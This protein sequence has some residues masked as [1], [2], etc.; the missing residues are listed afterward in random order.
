MAK[1]KCLHIFFFLYIEIEGLEQGLYARVHDGAVR[2]TYLKIYYIGAE[3][4]NPADICF[5]RVGARA[6]APCRQP[7]IQKYIYVKWRKNNKKTRLTTT[8]YILIFMLFFICTQISTYK[9][10]RTA[11]MIFAHMMRMYTQIVKIEE[12]KKK[13]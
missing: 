1:K 11:G 13:I 10:T 12:K 9:D 7:H 5:A 8:P 3:K 6:R 2:E 4:Q